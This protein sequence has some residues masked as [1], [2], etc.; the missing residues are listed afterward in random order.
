M[1]IKIIKVSEDTKEKI[2]RNGNIFSGRGQGNG[3]GQGQMQG[4]GQG[5]GQGRVQGFG[6]CQRRRRG[7]S[8]I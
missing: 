1:C 4:R 6:Q 3:R 5:N 8:N 2:M 7:L